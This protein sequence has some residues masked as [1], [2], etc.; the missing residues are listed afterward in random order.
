MKIS[1]IFENCE[2]PEN[3][4]NFH[5]SINLIFKNILITKY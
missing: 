2:K 5:L 3:P 4:A 1:R